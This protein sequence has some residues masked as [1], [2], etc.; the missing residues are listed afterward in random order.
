MSNTLTSCLLV[1]QKAF[2]PLVDEADNV[3]HRA[4]QAKLDASRRLEKERELSKARR[5]IELAQEE[6]NRAKALA[7]E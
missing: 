6:D 7:D 3:Q 5:V 2:Q 4:A 1:W